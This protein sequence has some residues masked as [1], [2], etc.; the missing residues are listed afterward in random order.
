MAKSKELNK[1]SKAE[2]NTLLK[3]KR[4]SLRKMRFDSGAGKLKNHRSIRNTKREI[5]KILTLLH[6]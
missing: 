1:K 2:L 4:E 5:A 6:A 3:Q